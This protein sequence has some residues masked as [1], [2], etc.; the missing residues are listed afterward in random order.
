M[1]KSVSYHE[2]TDYLLM[3][4]YDANGSPIGFTVKNAGGRETY[5]YDKNLQGDVVS[6]YNS[7]GTVLV[8]YTY[9]AWGVPTVSYVNGGASTSVVKNSLRYRGYYYDADLGMYYL[10]S[11]YYDAKVCR[12]ISPDKYISTGQGLLGCNMFAYCNNNPIVGVDP[13]GNCFHRRDFW[14]DCEECGGRTLGEKLADYWDRVVSVNQQQLLV[15]QS[16]VSKQNELI[17]QAAESVWDAYIRG[18]ELQAQNELMM[19]TATVN[20]I[21]DRFSTPEK[22]ANTLEGVAYVTDVLAFALM[23]SGAVKEAAVVEL[24]GI[25]LRGVIQIIEY[26]ME[27]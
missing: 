19:Q 14:N 26:C 11:R 16:V 18:L 21:L 10:Q 23:T 3:Y 27:E 15:N 5:W 13:C 1:T 9:D 12:F 4:I 17:A 24:I 2:S 22:A 20:F 6:V 25:G 7:A 8:N